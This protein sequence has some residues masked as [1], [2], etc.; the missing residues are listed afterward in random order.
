MGVPSTYFG[1]YE[2]TSSISSEVTE[3]KSSKNSKIFIAKDWDIHYSGEGV[4]LAFVSIFSVYTGVC[5]Q[6]FISLLD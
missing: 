2:I 1:P 3:F 5:P 6:F 4:V